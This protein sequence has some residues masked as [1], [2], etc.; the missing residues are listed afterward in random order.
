M[1][2]DRFEGEY[3]FLSNFYPCK[4][5]YNGIT[6]ESSEEAFQ[7]QKTLDEEVRKTFV[8]VGSGK[9]KKMGRALPDL[10]KDWEEVKD[11]IMRGIVW[12]KFAQN[13]DI[14]DKLFQT[15]NNILME[16]NSWGDYY[17]GTDFVD[18]QKGQ[19]RLGEIL[20]M[21][22]ATLPLIQMMP[23]GQYGFNLPNQPASPLPFGMMPE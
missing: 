13:P 23:N 2:I 15:G 4:V 10:R 16:G 17:W 11:D 14:A 8:G 18:H 5:T 9:A 7:A 12:N 3:F 19:N 21:V 1:I 20:M 6:Y 22:R